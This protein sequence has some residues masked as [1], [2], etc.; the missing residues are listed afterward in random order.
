[1][2]AQSLRRLD[3]ATFLDGGRHWQALLFPGAGELSGSPDACAFTS[4]SSHPASFE[5]RCYEADRLRRA[6]RQV[7]RFV[8][9]NGLSSFVTLT[10]ATA[11]SPDRAQELATRAFR[12]CRER[13]GPFPFVW[14]LERG[15]RHRRVHVHA[16]TA[17]ARAAL[18]AGRWNEGRSDIQQLNE[19]FESLRAGA[20]YFSKS[21]NE[22]PLV[23]NRLYRVAT[24]FAPERVL[25][26]AD[27][28]SGLI[29]EAT[30]RMGE[31]PAHEWS[32][33]NTVSARWVR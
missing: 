7:R 33:P 28:P 14:M 11:V 13:D 18:V 4:S 9:A 32:G 8:V 31:A 16:L 23:D 27:S 20:G 24:G 6:V 26:R 17:P 29:A 3:I 10:F 30:L 15:K 2:E 12:R 5:G 19:D 25:I 1:M 22:G 21:F